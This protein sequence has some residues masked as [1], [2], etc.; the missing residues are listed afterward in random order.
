MNQTQKGLSL[1]GVQAFNR[2]AILNV[3][4]KRGL[5]SRAEISAETELDQATVTRAVN[6]LI[7]DGLVEEVSLMKG[8]RGRR[9]IGLSLNSGR[10]RVIAVRLQ[11]LTFSI[12]CFD[13]RGNA[14]DM[15]ETAIPRQQ[16]LSFSLRSSQPS[17]RAQL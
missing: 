10:F 6:S 7:E 13:L 1:K 14:R 5:C 16:A 15:I 2:S 3:I 8:Q 11:R 12:A 9:S 4:H 17:V